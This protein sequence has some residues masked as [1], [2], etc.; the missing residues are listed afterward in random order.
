MNR[1]V[2]LNRPSGKHFKPRLCAAWLRY[3]G[4]FCPNGSACPHADGIQE[5]QLPSFAQL[6]RFKDQL[7]RIPAEESTL[8]AI[9]TD[10]LLDP[11]E[12]LAEGH[13]PPG[14]IPLELQYCLLIAAGLAGPSVNPTTS[15]ARV[16]ASMGNEAANAALVAAAAAIGIVDLN[17]F[18]ALSE[19]EAEESQTEAASTMSGSLQGPSP[20]AESPRLPGASPVQFGRS[21]SANPA[22]REIQEVRRSPLLFPVNFADYSL[23][24]QCSD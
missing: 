11:E 5:L 22:L 19:E 12:L 4:R 21:L 15:L 23:P 14:G 8:R 9:P 6:I 3:G 2:V 20:A 7:R 24:R 17:I 13:I 1:F 16:V 10:D 18:A